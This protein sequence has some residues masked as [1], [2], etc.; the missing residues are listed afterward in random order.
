MFQALLRFFSK[1]NKQSSQCTHSDSLTLAFDTGYKTEFKMSDGSNSRTDQYHLSYKECLKC[2]KRFVKGA[3]WDLKIV[4]SERQHAGVQKSKLFWIDHN[5]LLLTPDSVIFE[6]TKFVIS[7]DQ[8]KL[9]GV[10]LWS[11]S[12]TTDI[13]Q[14]FDELRTNK[15]FAKYVQHHMVADALN[16]L[17]TVTKLHENIDTRE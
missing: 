17:E 1:S 9:S 3:S 12:G 4:A 15:T 2:G 10:T 6:P 16:Q 8:P 7:T 5:Q 14:I 13:D 11:R